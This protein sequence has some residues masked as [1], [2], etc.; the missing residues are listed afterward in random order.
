MT[1]FIG[2]ACESEN[3]AG[4]AL[5]FRQKYEERLQ[6]MPMGQHKSMSLSMWLKPT[7]LTG[8]HTL[9][10]YIAAD[11]D[12]NPRPDGSMALELQGGEVRFLVNGNLPLQL[13]FRAKLQLDEW[14]LLTVTYSMKHQ[15]RLGTGAASVY[16]DG[17]LQETLPFQHSGPVFLG[18][19]W[20]GGQKPFGR[21]YSGYLDELR[22]WSRVLS[23]LEVVSSTSGR[24]RGTT[25]G[26]QAYYRFDEGSGRIAVDMA[27][28]PSPGED[29]GADPP[30]EAGKGDKAKPPLL[31][32]DLP[33]RYDALLAG[34][35]GT[36]VWEASTC[37]IE[38]CPGRPACSNKGRC[39][40]GKCD[41]VNGFT[42]K[43][44]SIEACPGAC[45]GHGRCV[46]FGAGDGV[47]ALESLGL[48]VD[49]LVTK[50]ETT[51]GA[52]ITA[53]LDPPI[54]AV[55]SDDI[56]ASR[57]KQAVAEYSTSAVAN[58]S[59]RI[60]SEE[61]AKVFSSGEIKRG[62]CICEEP[63]A[64]PNCESVRCPKDCSGHGLCH[65][66]NCICEE[67]F[68]G[69]DCSEVVCVPSPDCSGNGACIKGE[70]VCNAGWA[71]DGCGTR[72]VCPN[73]CTGHGECERG[74]ICKCDPEYTGKD[75]A[76]S[77]GCM[78]FCSGR[79]DC[80]A[81][82]CICDPL[83]TGPDCSQVAC[84]GDCSENGDCVHGLCMCEAGYTGD[85]CSQNALW[86]LRC[87]T[88]RKGMSTTS[89]CS[90]GWVNVPSPGSKV[91]D[92]EFEADKPLIV[93]T[94]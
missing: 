37:P 77:V 56:K 67:G 41:C 42:G 83:F 54:E 17:L 23:P 91:L 53:V 71:D 14:Q 72:E 68:A 21:F 19:G 90:R 60:L 63:Y 9:L 74:G 10:H 31:G 73:D 29:G 55:V 85:D 59:T 52:D 43:D 26:L 27:K 89:Q 66:G 81:D 58:V 80:V 78:N 7:N 51:V 33:S 28:D 84:P 35:A 65:E 86:P 4:Y 40:Q 6:L 92:L 69:M 48:D 30:A 70:C 3:Y 25:P 38:P 82:K 8:W 13:N 5:Q 64:P 22:I 76:W 15:G 16:V 34:T 47:K 44:C 11:A 93:E 50:L 94:R 2:I 18:G 32:K 57:T 62:R 24:T 20:F 87:T 61:F 12:S 49:A 46:E 36:P 45:A 39:V 75:C 88:V 79:G 1:G